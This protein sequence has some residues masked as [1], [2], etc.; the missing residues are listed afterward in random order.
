VLV[1]DDASG[2]ERDDGLGEVA[3]EMHEVAGNLILILVLLHVA[4]VA[5]ESRALRRNLLRPMLFGP[6]E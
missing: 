1:D 5:V 3:E 4:G 2:D 6:R